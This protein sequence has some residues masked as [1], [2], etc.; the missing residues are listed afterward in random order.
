[1]LPPEYVI[2]EEESREALKMWLDAE[3]YNAMSAEERHAVD[4][5]MDA[6]K[7]GQ[8]PVTAQQVYD[9]WDSE[10][11]ESERKRIVA[12]PRTRFIGML[13]PW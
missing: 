2:T 13:Q 11:Q 9:R 3:G 1:M 7:L 5:L 12:I 6:D 4:V 8:W 10:R